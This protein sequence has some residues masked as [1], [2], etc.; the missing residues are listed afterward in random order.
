MN[1]S[2]DTSKEK[3]NNRNKKL[4][5]QSL[6][7]NSINQNY[8][9]SSFINEITDITLNKTMELSQNEVNIKN[10]GTKTTEGL[11]D[12]SINLDNFDPFDE[13]IRINSPR[14]LE[15]CF[16]NGINPSFLYHKS[17]EQIKSIL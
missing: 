17:Y 7:T 9:S 16:N 4:D 6:M 3:I 11:K 1:D 14:S 15:V 12:N 10:N 2:Q 8:V 13:S 5:A